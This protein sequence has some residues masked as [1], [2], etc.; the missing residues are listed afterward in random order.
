L[1]AAYICENNEQ[2]VFSLQSPSRNYVFY[3]L[4][5]IDT[6]H[7][8][9]EIKAAIDSEMKALVGNVGEQDH[10]EIRRK[11]VE[12]LFAFDQE[13][14]EKLHTLQN[15]FLQ[16]LEEATK[17]KD[18]P[19]NVEC[20]NALFGPFFGE[21][22]QQSFLVRK[23]KERLKNWEKLPKVS[24]IYNSDWVSGF[25][26][27]MRS[28]QAQQ[29]ALCVARENPSFLDW[30]SQR[31]KLDE[32]LNEK[33]NKVLSLSDLLVCP[34]KHLSTCC[35][36]FQQLVEHTKEPEELAKLE[37]TFLKIKQIYEEQ[38]QK[39]ELL[40]EGGEPKDKKKE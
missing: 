16:P 4:K 8:Y 18:P 31:C 32:V 1:S 13:Y 40:N 12:T 28:Q 39:S 22:E 17:N 36:I 3:A 25:K 35:G 33:R 26:V 37:L 23:M 30:E 34:L 38:V 15:H 10:N 5:S 21:S 20:Y 24:D 2:K 7:W 29:E 19:L 27:H 14:A 11:L 6:E 9:K